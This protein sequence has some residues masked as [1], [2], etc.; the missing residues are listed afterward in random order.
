MNRWTD[1]QADWIWVNC[2]SGAF[3]VFL[4]SKF[5]CVPFSSRPL[6]VTLVFQSKTQRFVRVG[7]AVPLFSTVSKLREMVAEEGKISPDQVSQTIFSMLYCFVR[8]PYPVIWT[9]LFWRLISL[10]GLFAGNPGWTKPVRVPVLLLGWWGSEL[11]CRRGQ[12]LRFP[13]PTLF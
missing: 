13:G 6:N 12:H 3:L 11:H 2:E 10:T 9:T 8:T 1:G 7:L 5:P 4:N